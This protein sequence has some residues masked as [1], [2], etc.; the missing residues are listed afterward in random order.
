MT[1]IG[2]DKLKCMLFV[3]YAQIFLRDGKMLDVSIFSNNNG[4]GTKAILNMLPITSEVTDLEA[5]STIHCG[6]V[7]FLLS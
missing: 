5:M 6:F 2:I 4:D 1:R 7:L 3:Q